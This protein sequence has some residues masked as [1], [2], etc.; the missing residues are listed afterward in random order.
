MSEDRQIVLDTETTGLEPSD[1]HRII[2]I[3]CVEMVNRRVTGNNYHQYLQP[4]R[5][6]DEGAVEVH[7]IT[8]EFLQD[9]P[10]MADVVEAFIDYVRG[11]EL[12]IHNAPFDVGFINHELALLGDAWGR[13]EDH[14]QITDT[15]EMAR[16]MRPGQRNTLDA[17]CKVYEVDNSNRTL[18]GALLDAQILAEVYL[19]MTGGQGS[20]MLSDELA[21][22]PGGSDSLISRIERRVELPIIAA[23]EKELAEHEKMLAMI[24]ETAGDVQT[25]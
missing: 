3:G 8:N 15:L 22:G 1:G 4:D 14:C 24:R 23:S 16:K 10:R 20:L 11:A 25:F 19:A 17:L 2:E 12:I 21:E 6:I 9:K 18:H 13:I 5:L 7:G